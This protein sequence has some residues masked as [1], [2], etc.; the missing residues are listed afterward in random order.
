M[1]RI[2]VCD[3]GLGGLNIAARFFT[4]NPEAAPCE[5]LYFNAYPDIGKGY[6]DLPSDEAKREVFRNAL[7]GMEAFSPDGCFI[8][9]NTLS[10]VFEKFQ[11]SDMPSF[12]VS[13]IADAAVD[14]MYEALAADETASLLILGTLT[15]V[16]SGLYAGRLRGKGVAPGRIRSL[17]CPGLAT[18]LEKGPLS[19][20]CAERI[21]RYADEARRLFDRPPETLLLGLCCTH[22]GFARELWEREFTRVFGGGVRIVDPNS[23][24]P[25]LYAAKTFRYLSRTALPEESRES[26]GR[27]FRDRASAIAQGLRI[28]EPMPELFEFHA[29]KYNL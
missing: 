8:A 15:T 7:R 1:K 12:P 27:F 20:D 26:M 9:C 24:P 22:F 6:N 13:G 18:A 19:S 16:G 10:I 23:R 4:E 2:I 5:L 28:A 14:S 25:V 3:S 17:A 29:E 11:P 21:A